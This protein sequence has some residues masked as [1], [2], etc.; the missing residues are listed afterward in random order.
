MDLPH[1]WSPPPTHTTGG[2]I[3]AEWIGLT[4][5]KLLQWQT[6]WLSTCWPRICQDFFGLLHCLWMGN[7]KLNFLLET[8]G[9]SPFSP[10]IE[11][12]SAHSTGFCPPCLCQDWVFFAEAGLGTHTTSL[13]K[14]PVEAWQ[15]HGWRRDL[16]IRPRTN[17][18]G[19]LRIHCIHMCSFCNLLIFVV[20]IARIG[21]L[22]RHPTP[23]WLLRKSWLAEQHHLDLLHQLVKVGASKRNRLISFEKVRD[24]GFEQKTKRSKQNGMNHWSSEFH[25]SQEHGDC[26]TA[27]NSHWYIN[28]IYVY[29]QI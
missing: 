23:P 20:F 3:A 22:H 17:K 15:F 18:T 26:E 4:K 12:C 24:A 21:D 2:G 7:K 27:S 8:S 1:S 14:R 29:L 25:K 9:S 6:S 5:A 13:A 16:C 11:I 10:N 28:Y 19:A